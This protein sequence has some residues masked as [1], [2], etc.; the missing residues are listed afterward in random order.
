[1]TD[2]YASNSKYELLATDWIERD[3]RRLYRVKALRSIGAIEPGDLGGYVE[4]QRNLAVGGDNSWVA[5]DAEVSG[6]ARVFRDAWV[7]G[8]AKVFGFAQIGGS[9]R[10]YGDAQVF[11]Y[12]RVFG[13]VVVCGT[14]RIHGQA[15]LRGKVRV[16]HG[17]VCDADQTGRADR[18]SLGLAQ[19]LEL[20]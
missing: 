2:S 14:A 13:F 17:V 16:D 3:G 20:G 12:A 7:G 8:H 9:A 10:V 19:V 5:G 11:D 1:M 6:Q 18:L 15:N 4:S